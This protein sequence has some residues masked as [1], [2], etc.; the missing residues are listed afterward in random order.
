MSVQTLVLNDPPAR[1]V[2]A[3]VVR[4]RL[5]AMRRGGCGGGGRL[6]QW[7]RFSF[8]DEDED[9]PL[10]RAVQVEAD[11]GLPALDFSA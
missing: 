5:D 6:G 10:R 3:G 2:C 9:F 4:A 7:R 11:S 1:A 8:Q